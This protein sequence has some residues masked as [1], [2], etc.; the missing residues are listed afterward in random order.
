MLL[1]T[2]RKCFRSNPLS[3]LLS[4]ATVAHNSQTGKVIF[5]ND[6]LL[7]IQRPVGPF[8]MNE[9]FLG[10]KQTG[11]AALIDLGED[12]DVFF[13]HVSGT[14]FTV[15]HLI[16]THAHI[17][18]VTGLA[19][20][21]EQ[22]PDA[23][24]YLHKRELTIYE[25]VEQQSRMFMVDCKLPLPDK[26][27]L[28]YIENGEKLFVGELEFEAVHTPGHSPGHLVYFLNHPSN[29][30]AFVGDLIFEGSIG[31]TDLPG[32]SVNDMQT[33]VI[34]IVKSFPDETI[35]LPGHMGTTTIGNEKEKNP[36]VR[37]WMRADER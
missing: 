18:H 32:C 14:M 21:H 6:N 12:P 2:A 36:F 37:D 34:Q 30:F 4:T 24:I 20:A 16:Q 5:D 23:P 29:P 9:Y 1:S 10:C 28:T 26:D 33:S 11:D 17:D 8:Q 7:L 13:S 3:K 35:L 19:D 22:Y 27:Q 25:S 31:R 15:K